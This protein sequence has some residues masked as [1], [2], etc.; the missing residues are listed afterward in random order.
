LADASG[1]RSVLFFIFDFRAQLV[2]R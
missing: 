1:H 2:H